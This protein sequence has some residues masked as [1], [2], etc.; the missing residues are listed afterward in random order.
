MEKYFPRG[1]R[2]DWIEQQDSRGNY[3]IRNLSVEEEAKKF[4]VAEFLRFVHP[5]NYFLMPKMVGKRKIAHWACF[6]DCSDMAEY[7]PF[8]N[9]VQE[10]FTNIY[11]CDYKEFLDLIMV[12][13]NYFA[14]YHSKIL[15]D[16]NLQISHETNFS[17]PFPDEVKL[18]VLREFLKNP[19]T[20]FRKLEIDIMK[21]KSPV[22]GGGFK[23]KKIINDFGAT[24]EDKGILAITTSLDSAIKKIKSEELK[25]F[26]TQ[27]RNFFED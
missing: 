20:S 16:I 7:L 4:L 18:K 25:I 21:I 12:D 6:E 23:S 19:N 10:Q 15:E 3:F 13:V 22:R 8:L 27:H 26:L 2:T 24:I 11:G 17:L 5:F 14:R 1:E 9:F